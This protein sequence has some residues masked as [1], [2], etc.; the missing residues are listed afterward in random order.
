MMN[1][2][3]TVHC[4]FLKPLLFGRW[5]YQIFIASLQEEP[6]PSTS[7]FSHSFL[8]T[9]HPSFLPSYRSL[10]WWRW[11]VYQ[12]VYKNVRMFIH[13]ST[14]ALWFNRLRKCVL[15]VCASFCVF[16]WLFGCVCICVC[17][18]VCL[19]FCHTSNCNCACASMPVLLY[20]C[21]NDMCLFSAHESDVLNL[22]FLGRDKEGIWEQWWEQL[23][24][25][26][27]RS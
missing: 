4:C 3:K 1:L 13:V 10:R 27:R 24:E 20:V 18:C 14:S 12:Y 23:L 19:S 6:Y 26:D 17:V 11:C 21:S 2:F 25:V 15:C 16:V 5:M 22:I 9:T 7:S 8:P